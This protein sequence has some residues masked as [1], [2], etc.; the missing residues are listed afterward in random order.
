[1]KFH[2]AVI[3]AALILVGLMIASCRS[4][5]LHPKEGPGT[6]Y[7][8]GVWGVECPD[9]S[10][11]PYKHEC[12]GNWRGLFSTCPAGYCCYRGGDDWPRTG[13]SDAGADAHAFESIVK[14]KNPRSP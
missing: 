7:P 10:C 1:M 12:G 4:D 9:H 8:C 6:A 3:A 14:A 11:C 5:L 2:H 13:A